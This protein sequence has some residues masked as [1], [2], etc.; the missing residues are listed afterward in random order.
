[1]EIVEYSP[2]LC[3]SIKCKNSNNQCPHLR[4]DGTD[5]CGIHLKSKN[6]IRIDSILAIPQNIVQ[7]V[8]KPKKIVK[9]DDTPI[10]KNK[11][12][13]RVL[14]NY[15]QFSR[16][17]ISIQKVFKGWN[18]RRRNKSNNKEDCGTFDSIYDIPI[19]YYF[20]YLDKDGF[21]YSFDLRTYEML[22]KI[23]PYNQKPFPEDENYNKK[24]VSKTNYIKKSD[25]KMKHDSPKL[26]DEQRFSQF[27]L[28]VF[29]KY[30]MIG[31]YTDVKW[32]ENLSF[33]ELKFFYKNA[34]DMFDYRAQMNDDT[35]KK[36]VKNGRPFSGIVNEVSLFRSKHKRLLQ[37]E[38]LKEM[39]KIADEG[40]DKEYKTLGINL[41]LT[42]LVELSPAAA[43]ALPHLVQSTFG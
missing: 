7:I 26:S 22:G 15:S 32:F 1:M 25:K 17:I 12:V 18:I 38:I 5:Y 27:M 19:E 21:T 11:E 39:E 2:L 40:E 29:Q 20:S 23:N 35:K 41:V 8:E 31:Q 28:R 37:I 10:I 43:I 33:D 6:L 42:V 16:E 30:D 14:N 34:F 4:K 13:D 36:I 3:M 24:L 9:N